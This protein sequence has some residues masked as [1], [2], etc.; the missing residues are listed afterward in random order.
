MR[1]S[2]RFVCV[3]VLVSA[4]CSI[5]YALRLLCDTTKA[6]HWTPF[7]DIDVLDTVLLYCIWTLYWVTGVSNSRCCTG[8]RYAVWLWGY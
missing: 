4:G 1:I 2:L 5:K 6:Q 3:Y 7:V 8:T